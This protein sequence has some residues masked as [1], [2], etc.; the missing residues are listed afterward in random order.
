MSSKRDTITT[1]Y[2]ATFIANNDKFPSLS[3]REHCA[4]SSNQIEK[5][6]LT[7]GQQVRIL[8]TTADGTKLALYTIKNVHNVGEY[9]E[10]TV[11]VGYED[12]NDL[13]ERFSAVIQILLKTSYITPII[14]HYIYLYKK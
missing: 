9:S 12:Q 8:R 7:L 3:H 14:L 11:L 6:G 5:I 13:W 1:A 10:D 2:T 4:V